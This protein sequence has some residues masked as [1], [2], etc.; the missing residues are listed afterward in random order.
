[1]SRTQHVLKIYL[2][3]VWVGLPPLLGGVNICWTFIIRIRQHG[4]HG[5]QDG[6]HRVD[7]Q[8]PL[9][10]FLIT[11]PVIAWRK[12]NNTNSL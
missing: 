3:E 10:G 6:L 1:M 4:Y 11:V 12:G 2:L 7:G 9:T 5:D 8:P